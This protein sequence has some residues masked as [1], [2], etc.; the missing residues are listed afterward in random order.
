MARKSTHHASWLHLHLAVCLSFL[1]LASNQLPRC[2]LA[3]S[4]NSSRSS[5]GGTSRVPALCR[6]QEAASLLQ[7]KGSFALPTDGSCDDNTALPS[8]RS[9]SDCCRWE[10]VSCDGITGRVTALHPSNPTCDGRLKACGGLH[11]ALFNLTSLRRLN[12]GGLDFCGSQLPESGLE[13]LTNLRVLMLESCNLS[14]TVPATIFTLPAL[15]E[16]HL[17]VNNFSGPIEEFHN[18]SGTLTEVYLSRNQLTGT[19]STSFLELTA[20]STIA[21]DYNHFT[22][23]VNL[24]SYSRLRSLFEFTASGNSLVSIVGDDRWTSGSS[25]SSISELAF[26]SCGLTR[27]P[28][29]I[30]HLPSLN[31]LDLSY[32]G[33]GG[34]IPDWI[35]RNHSRWLDLS[36]NMFTEVARPPAYTVI[37]YI[38]LSFNR[39]RGAVPS[40]S[41][42]S[43]SHLDYSNNKFS[44]MLPGDFL[45]L[46]GTAAS[47]NLANN[48]L[49][50][51]IPYAGCDQFHYEEE[52]GRKPL[53]D[54]DLSGN[55]FSGQVPPYVLRG[56]N[57]N[58]LR[59]LNLRGN[60]LEGTWPQEMGGLC[61]LEAVDLHGNQI[62]G[63]LPRWLANCKELNGLDVGGNNLVDSFP[64]WLGNLP[65]LRVL[66]L[67]SNQFYGPVTTVS[68]DPHRKNHHHSSLQIIDLAENGFTGVLPSG[69]FYSFKTMAQANTMHKI[70]KVIMIGYRG[71]T[72]IHQEGRLTQ[73]E[74]AM[75]HR[76]MMMLEDQQLDLVLIDL[77]NNR[78]SGSIPRS[79]GNLTGLLVLNLSRN[80]FTGEIPAELG[81]LSQVE[82]L[83][84]SWN[85]LTGE[86]PQSLASLTAL[87]WLNL[88]YNDL[89]GSIPPGTQF[90]T[91]PSSSFQ[92]GNRG[93]YGCPLPV[94]CNLTR[95]PSATKAPPPLHMPGGESAHHS[96]QVVVLCLFVGAGFG[97]GFALAI[98][99]QVVCS[100]RG[101]R[102]WLCRAN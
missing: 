2:S 38:D 34:K 11:P 78:F 66:I 74:V 58:T 31:W 99:L 15:V 83:D 73:V 25:N 4:A 28:S 56:C 19:I 91:F 52:G 65:H 101:A 86:I 40:P 87:E 55:N 59:V 94:R 21:L 100:R 97:L 18:A 32:N 22:G 84:L 29:V 70:R 47:I 33:I 26:A 77:S 68:M 6:S 61:R 98:V 7:L 90:S 89:S 85:N 13:R 16:L 41:L 36:H 60:R 9:G 80:A 42:L 24:S 37:S 75:K 69:L 10:G 67:R 96:F 48:Q 76:Y 8:W 51:T 5:G 1:L 30:R 62:R 93:L 88:S 53:R 46:Y 45:M 14:G 63:R 102:K 95:P 39:L 17:Q 79:V 43:A 3:L 12:L 23:T 35:W 92:G 82:S 72:D 57:N 50:G 64:S 49:G 27:L 71:E 81:R 20:L 54:L 44:S